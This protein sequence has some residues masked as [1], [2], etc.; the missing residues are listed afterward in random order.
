MAQK[1]TYNKIKIF[2]DS[3]DGFILKKVITNITNIDSEL[4][5]H[6]EDDENVFILKRDDLINFAG[7]NQVDFLNNLDSWQ[8]IKSIDFFFWDEKNNDIQNLG[9]TLKGRFLLVKQKDFISSLSIDY[10][11][12]DKL[13]SFENILN[14]RKTED[15]NI[16][17]YLDKYPL[18]KSIKKLKK[19]LIK[20]HID[21]LFVHFLLDNNF[22]ASVVNYD[23]N[24][25]LYVLGSIDNIYWKVIEAY[26][27]LYSVN[28]DI[29]FQR[30]EYIVENVELILASS[31]LF[32]LGYKN[33]IYDHF[34]FINLSFRFDFY[35]RVFEDINNLENYK[36]F[37]FEVKNNFELLNVD[38]LKRSVSFYRYYGIIS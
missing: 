26:Q 27:K 24:M 34:K 3:I 6:S 38:N 28:T 30:D 14:L 33:G 10:Q 18:S 15:S 2:S 32:F 5:Y 35:K 13:P 7:L 22:S 25:F 17:L 11:S 9:I 21:D 16:F 1:Q 20:S 12:V 19:L 36:N 31:N 4:I 29:V 8:D 23:G 37:W